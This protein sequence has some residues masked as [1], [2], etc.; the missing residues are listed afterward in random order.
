M[1]GENTKV[2]RK[3]GGN[4]LVVASGGRITVEAGGH[5]VVKGVDLGALPTADPGDGV[6]IWIDNGA[7]KV[8]SGP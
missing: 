5:L 4:E 8:A 7:L 6:H 3:Q 1:A 2:H